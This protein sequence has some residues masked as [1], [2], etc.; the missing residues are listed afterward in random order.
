MPKAIFD[1]VLRFLHIACGIKGGGDKPDSE[2][3]ERFLAHD[4][5]A[6]S[7]LLQRHGPM[8]L[9]ICRRLSADSHAAEDG[10]QATFMV[11][12][13]HAASIRK[14]DSIAPWLYGVTR[15]VVLKARAKAAAS[16]RRERRILNMADTD[17][18]Q[19]LTVRDLRSCLDEEIAQLPVK[20]QAPIL[21]CYF[22]GKSQNQAAQELGW[23]KNTLANRLNRGLELLRRQLTRRGITL[24]GATLATALTEIAAAPPL[25][26][27]LAVNTVKAATLLA[28]GK[29]VASGCLTAT[30]LALAEETL[31]G[32]L[33]V[34]GKIIVLV[35]ALGLT[36]GGAGWAGYGRLV[37]TGRA[38]VVGL[39]QG[40][41]Q[42]KQADGPAKEEKVV[43]KDQYGD[44]LPDGAVARL[45]ALRFRH[46]GHISSEGLVFTPDGKNL[47][48]FTQSGVIVWEVATGKEQKR[49][50]VTFPLATPGCVAVSPDGFTLAT[51]VRGSDDDP[52]PALNLWDL[53]TGKKIITPDLP[54]G[55][56]R[57]VSFTT[58][59]KSLVVGGWEP[60]VIDLASG[61]VR[62]PFKN[63]ILLADDKH[64]VSPDNKTLALEAF[65]PGDENPKH[66]IQLRDIA[67]GKLIHTFLELPEDERSSSI[68]FSPDGKKLAFN[69][70][71]Q[72]FLYDPATGNKLKQFEDN[73]EWFGKLV[74]TP[75][76]KKLISLGA[77]TEKVVIGDVPTKIAIWDVVTGKILSAIRLPKSNTFS[78]MAVAPNGK[79][80]ALDPGATVLQLWDLAT[81]KELL[82]DYESQD[83]FINTLAYSADGKTLA[84]GGFGPVHLWDAKTWKKTGT[85]PTIAARP[86][87]SPLGRTLALV[88]HYTQDDVPQVRIRDL[89]SNKADLVLK[90][91]NEDDI[92]S[93][94]FSPDGKQLFTLSAK[95]DEGFRTQNEC[96]RHWDLS[97]GKQIW[98]WNTSSK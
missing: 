58:D 4:E 46:E 74:F 40:P 53:R 43:A 14:K 3:L 35:M 2:L 22:E 78:A 55:P 21:L 84:A 44:P 10:F 50:P 95:W 36:V 62:R 77:Y 42:K 96:V 79:T 88:E 24:A 64:A 6:F 57:Q 68:T 63:G 27:I 98:T 85:I 38:E 16:R 75:D 37:E 19:E 45:G 91:P 90:F 72:I 47:V 1:D 81:G 76:S 5:G 39:E 33:V 54:S 48:G 92:T 66:T 61:K 69:C 73:V 26:A 86:I 11:L 59:G 9:N 13:R 17:P 83:S 20:Y 34:K 65:L 51:G 70:R 94:H 29:S 93:T 71:N 30:A 18:L 32:M 23:P 41:T 52:L 60:Y 67:S 31:T 15:R 7:L 25:P 49:L 8:I 56:C 89:T 87:F 12:V 28:A 80:L 82:S 97:S